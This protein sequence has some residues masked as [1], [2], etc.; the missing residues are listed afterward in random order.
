MDH[1]TSLCNFDVNRTL[2][3]KLVIQELH[4][5]LI[6]NRLI[7]DCLHIMWFKIE[8]INYTELFILA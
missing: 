3:K 7:K 4:V 6:Y 8:I 2:Y 5:F 1:G